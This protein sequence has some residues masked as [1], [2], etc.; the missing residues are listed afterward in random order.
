ML[1]RLTGSI[2]NSFSCAIDSLQKLLLHLCPS[3][4]SARA[5]LN[6]LLVSHSSEHGLS[7]EQQITHEHHDSR[8]LSC[9]SHWSFWLGEVYVRP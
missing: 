7:L 4:T 1:M 6:D 2:R 9:P 8:S 5:A 3:T